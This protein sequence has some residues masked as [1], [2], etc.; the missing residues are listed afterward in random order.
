[1]DVVTG[2]V[3][4]EKSFGFYKLAVGECGCKQFRWS[5]GYRSHDDHSFEL[6]R[7]GDCANMEGTMALVKVVVHEFIVTSIYMDL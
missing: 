3:S 6:S 5:G 7:D 4:I 1:M 2:R